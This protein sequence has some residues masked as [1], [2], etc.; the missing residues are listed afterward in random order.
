[1]LIVISDARQPD[2]PIVLANDS[3]LEL[4]GYS[5]D[6]LFLNNWRHFT[7]DEGTKRATSVILSRRGANSPA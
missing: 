4:T 1:M 2:Y 5:A 6:Q 7:P 3:F